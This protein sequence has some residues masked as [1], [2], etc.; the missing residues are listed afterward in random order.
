VADDLDDVAGLLAAPVVGLT[1][2]QLVAAIR[3]AEQIRAV[4][5]ER[6]G[7]LLAELHV[8]GRSWPAIARET[9]LRQTTAYEWA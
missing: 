7:R 2:T 4:S 6:T 3:Q 8:R 9:G 5:R 1:D